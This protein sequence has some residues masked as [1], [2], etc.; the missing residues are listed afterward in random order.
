VI[1]WFQNLLFQIL[2]VL[3]HPG[4]PG[5]VFARQGAPWE[6]NLR[7]LLRWCDLAL[8]A[9]AAE[10]EEE[11]EEGSGLA[12]IKN[13]DERMAA[14]ERAVEATFGTLFSQR[15]RTPTDRAQCSKLF[16]EAFGRLPA[17]RPPP[18]VVRLYKSNAVE[19]IARERLVCSTLE[20]EM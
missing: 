5:G 17:F 1:S 14:A 7:D 3:L 8:S 20:P 13:D 4:V 9:S 19:S 15:L 11:G 2:P 16:A 10:Q 18:A 12:L 6:F